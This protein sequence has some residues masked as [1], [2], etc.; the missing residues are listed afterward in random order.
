MNSNAR[1]IDGDAEDSE[2]P[3]KRIRRY[4]APTNLVHLQRAMLAAI[5]SN[6]PSKFSELLDLFTKM[7]G[8][9][10]NGKIYFYYLIRVL[11]EYPE[12]RPDCMVSLL[13]HDPNR[14]TQEIWLRVAGTAPLAC[15]AACMAA[16][17]GPEHKRAYAKLDI[18][19]ANPAHIKPSSE[20]QHTIE[21]IQGN[22]AKVEWLKVRG[23][24]VK[25]P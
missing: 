6:E 24:Q 8:W 7:G 4:E 1:P 23:I 25:W 12:P 20:V 2:P 18:L 16:L 21:L 14:F 15:M 17:V 3:S 13:L 11:C 22:S 5:A 9:N 19:G 10:T